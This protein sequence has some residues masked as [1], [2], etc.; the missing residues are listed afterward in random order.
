MS[1]TK[2][3]RCWIPSYEDKT[4]KAKVK[5][6]IIVIFAPFASAVLIWGVRQVRQKRRKFDRAVNTLKETVAKMSNGK[7]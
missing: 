1:I 2:N 3:G 6:A 4:R 7:Y 5:W